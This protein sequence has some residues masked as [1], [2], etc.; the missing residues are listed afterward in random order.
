MSAWAVYIDGAAER[1]ETIYFR[2]NLKTLEF[3]QIFN[4]LVSIGV[5]YSLPEPY[6]YKTSLL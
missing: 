5:A 1:K 6:F 2:S 3:G 4:D